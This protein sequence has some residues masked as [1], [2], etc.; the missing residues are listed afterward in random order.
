VELTCHAPQVSDGC[1]ESND[2][3]IKKQNGVY[4]DNN[5]T[6]TETWISGA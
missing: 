4:W 5:V 3:N 2:Y 1:A 6:A